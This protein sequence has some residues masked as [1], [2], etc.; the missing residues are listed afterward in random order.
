MA[1]PPHDP[2]EVLRAEIL[3][4]ARREGAEVIRRAQTA[5]AAL[6]DQ[7]TT[8]AA[9]YRAARLAE[10]RAEAGRRREII[11]AAVPGAAARIRAARVEALLET[12][13]EE[14]RCRLVAGEGV[15]GRETIVTL[16]A[17]AV[18]HMA[19]R[20]F[21]VKLAP[22]DRVAWG[23]GLVADM[24]RRC[25]DATLS[26]TLADDPAIPPGGVIIQDVAG[27]QVWDNRLEQ[28]LA[29]MWPELRRQIAVQ[30]ALVPARESAGGPA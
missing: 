20:E 23:V 13:R 25:G 26:L 19:G 5:A 7:A 18:G 21:I 15:A 24:V 2:A 1:N 3:A 30:T 29:R 9:Q 10:A 16:A 11:L 4:A 28:R 6:Y 14:A 17:E 22:A 8:E 27:R 12:I